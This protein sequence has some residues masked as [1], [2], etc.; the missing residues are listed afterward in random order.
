MLKLILVLG[1]FLFGIM[2]DLEMFDIFKYFEALFLYLI[3]ELVPIVGVDI[4]FSG[5]DFG[6]IKYIFYPL[7]FFQVY[8]GNSL[9]EY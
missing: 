7:Q 6:S 5:I 4:K 9:P 1:V 2:I 8:S 3:V